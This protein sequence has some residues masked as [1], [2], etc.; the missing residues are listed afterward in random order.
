MKSYKGSILFDN[1]ANL[2]MRI[3]DD[4]KEVE[5]LTTGDVW[6]LGGGS[7]DFS[8]AEV[9]LTWENANPFVFPFT[10]D[11]E[12]FNAL[13]LDTFAGDGSVTITV[14]LYKGSCLI[15]LGQDNDCA[16]TGDAE[17]DSGNVM[18]TGDCSVTISATI[19]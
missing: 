18:I 15:P 3:S 14:P 11:E 10:Y 2:E 1:E 7:S 16:V 4:V 5:N 13:I 19:E 12:G 8:T 17:V 6:Q 9:T